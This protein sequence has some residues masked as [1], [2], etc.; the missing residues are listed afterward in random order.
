MPIYE[1]LIDVQKKLKCQKSQYNSFGKYHYRS[2]EDIIEGAKPLCCENGLLL[3]ISDEIQLIGSRHYIK[4]TASVTDGK[5]K[6]EVFGYA[7]EEETKKGMDGSQIT[8]AASS[9]ARKYALNGLFCI[10][11]TKDADTDEYQ[12]Q[13]KQEVKT[14]MPI[15]EQQKKVLLNNAENETV[16]KALEFYKKEI[17]D[18]TIV[19]ASTII[20]KIMNKEK[21]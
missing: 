10:D 16:K 14:Q 2:C 11:D 13:V 3:T 4:S 5:D 19:E 15:S 18:L 7:R 12:K 21:E 1:K 6:I 20:K 9:Y 17:D 8:G